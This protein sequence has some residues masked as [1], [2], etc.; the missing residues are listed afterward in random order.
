ME[1]LDDS[2]WVRHTGANPLVPTNHTQPISGRIVMKQTAVCNLKR[3]LE[4]GAWMD[5]A[6]L[7]QVIKYHFK[8]REKN[9]E[10]LNMHRSQEG[11]V[12]M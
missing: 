9:G 4:T 12:R 10:H 6:I 11:Q 7:R 1:Q 2:T 5:T 8:H 3:I